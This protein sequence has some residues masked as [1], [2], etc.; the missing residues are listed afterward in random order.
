MQGLLQS[1]PLG[2]KTAVEPLR[3]FI[4][5][6]FGR[7]IGIRC[8]DESRKIEVVGDVQDLRIGLDQRAIMAAG[9]FFVRPDQ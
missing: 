1:I 2:A 5:A 3:Y 4:D 6:Q 8:V 9:L 7:R